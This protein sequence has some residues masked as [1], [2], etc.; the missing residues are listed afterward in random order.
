MSRQAVDIESKNLAKGLMTENL[1]PEVEG[2][3]GKPIRLI[4]LWSKNRPEWTETLLACMHY[5]I[6][7]VG[8][9]DAMGAAQMDFILN[10]TQLPSMIVAPEYIPKVLQMKKDGQAGYV[11]NL[12]SLGESDQQAG[13]E[14]AG[15]KLVQ[16]TDVVKAGANASDAPAFEYP[17][18]FDSYIFSYTS[19]TTGDSKGVKLT[20]NSI[21]KQAIQG[22]PGMEAREG[23]AVIS[24]LPYPH[25]FEQILLAVTLCC[26]L[27]VGFYQGDPLKLVEDCGF[28]KPAF[29]PS[30]PRLY[31]RIYSKIKSKFDAETGCKKWL[32]ERALS[33]KLANL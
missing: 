16:F 13:C 5:R 14:A 12:I 4:G 1:A 19:G 10:Q 6:V 8:F 11:K 7:V 33:T 20:H 26:K 15:I 17:D 32:I 31:T 30:V 22:I 2:E 24:Y 25:S 27:R 28:L 9:F 18:K 21:L 23:D 3:E 29:F